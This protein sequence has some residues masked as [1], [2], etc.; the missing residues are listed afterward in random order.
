[1]LSYN[2][3]S[4]LK[5]DKI[6]MKKRPNEFRNTLRQETEMMKRRSGSYL[7]RAMNFEA[8]KTERTFSLF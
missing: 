6:K 2:R 8:K 1:M 5:T 7:G 3:V 4:F